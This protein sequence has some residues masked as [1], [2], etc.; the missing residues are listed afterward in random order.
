MTLPWWSFPLT[1]LASLLLTGLLRRQAL[2]RGR[3]DIPNAR[4]SH[5]VPTPRGGGLAIV[6]VFLAGLSL[7]LA[8]GQIGWS[9]FLPLAGAGAM[10]A[11]VGWLDDRG[12]VAPGRRLAVH[13]LA[14]AWVLFWL[15]PLPPLPLWPGYAAE[16]GW[17]G[18]GLGALFLVWL[19]NL[20]N[21]MDGIDGLAASEA[22]SVSLA[23]AFLAWQG[24]PDRGAS[25]PPLLL[26]AASA[27]FLAWNFPR[28]RIFMG[29]AGS[30]FLG[31]VLGIF[32]LQAGI[33]RPGLFWA[34]VILLGVFVVDATVTLVRRALRGERLSEAHRSHAYQILA[35]RHG[36]HARV[37]MGAVAVN[38]CWLLPLAF[39]AARFPGAALFCLLVAYLPLVLFAVRAGAGEERA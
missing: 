9:S 29:D 2:A 32:A 19:L 27:G 4:S 13:F 11:L 37:T 30:G 21:F 10:V 25:L 24:L 20:Y 28:A 18:Q 39:T 34:W 23:G 15:G 36:S 26:A 5:Q 12:H 38:L 14:A 17:A 3:L 8:G 7:L 31:L 22:I 6:A 33:S 35:R 16:L 1:L